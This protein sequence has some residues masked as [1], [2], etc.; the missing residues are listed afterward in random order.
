[1]N[2]CTSTSQHKESLD[3]STHRV[4]KGKKWVLATSLIALS[5]VANSP[6]W[7]GDYTHAKVPEAPIH[8]TSLSIQI[9]PGGFHFGIGVPSY[10]RAYGHSYGR[11]G[12]R[13]YWKQSRHHHRRHHHYAE[14]KRFNRGHGWKNDRHRGNFGGKSGRG[15]SGRGGHRGGRR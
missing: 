12:P 7:A 5:F 13:P 1:M 6:V 3:T 10:G 9:G 15:G 8:L 2:I 14:P 11:P 4:G